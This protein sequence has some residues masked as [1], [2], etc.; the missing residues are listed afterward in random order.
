MEASEPKQ[1][2][3]PSAVEDSAVTG[4]GPGGLAPDK[5]VRRADVGSSSRRIASVRVG[6]LGASAWLV[7]VAVPVAEGGVYSTADIVLA[8]LPV[9][10]LGL[11]VRFFARDRTEATPLLAIAFPTLI[12]TAMAGRADP[13]LADRY[14]T[15]LVILSGLAML[16][17]VIAAAH[18]LARPSVFRETRVSKLAVLPD[19][20]G[21]ARALRALVLGTAALAGFVLT[22]VVPS[23]GSR[24]SYAAAWADAADE[25][26]VL[27]AI[28]AAAVAT[29]ALT[30]IIGPAL[31]AP[32]PGEVRSGRDGVTIAASIVVAAT[33]VLAWAILRF[34]GR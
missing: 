32:R 15:P 5:A 33:G 3:A 20:S 29:F 9:L 21:R 25:G 4:Q 22:I 26:R 2:D 27:V 30:V 34:S 13:A 8:V 1:E 19:P 23:I 18:A 16:A 14:G 10:A 31:R 17:Y 24:A 12:A 7:S 11:G 6:T 28:L